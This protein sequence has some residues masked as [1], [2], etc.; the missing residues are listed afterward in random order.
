MK[1]GDWLADEGLLPG[2]VVVSLGGNIGSPVQLCTR[3]REAI[4]TLSRDWGPARASAFYR[5]APLGA[6]A[7]QADFYNA[8]A[9]WRPDPEQSPEACLFA[10]QGLELANGRVRDVAGGPRT[11]DLDLLLV[12]QLWRSHEALVLPH[13][14]MHQR[15][16][17][18]EP[19]AELFG[20]DFTWGV[21]V[22]LGDVRADLGEQRCQAL[23]QDTGAAP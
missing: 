10:L 16:F 7:D 22:R 23:A 3:M 8:V 14:R 21:Q 9:A 4:A 5:S 15:A 17:V 19:L 13:P 2:V 11:L 18:L 1:A 6:V 12:G 20:D